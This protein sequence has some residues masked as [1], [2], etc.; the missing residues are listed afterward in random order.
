MARKPLEPEDDTELEAEPEDTRSPED[1]MADRIAEGV[2][3]GIEASAP[4]KVPY[5]RYDPMSPNQKGMPK[6]SMP[7]LTREC[8]QNGERMNGDLMTAEEIKL[9][10]LLTVPGRYVDRRVEVV[11]RENVGDEKPT[12]ELRYSD[13]I[14][15]SFA[16]RGKV[17]VA[18]SESPLANMLYHI[19]DEVNGV[20]A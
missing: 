9:M 16:L 19:L 20:L 5:G 13:T 18:K 8:F 17:R 10:N 14:N 1:R 15:E 7:K 3:R 12:V 6:K 11:I 4:K 2:A